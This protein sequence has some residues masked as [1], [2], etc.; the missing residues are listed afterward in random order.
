M[1]PTSQE[2][3]VRDQ[4]VF[5]ETS[6]PECSHFNEAYWWNFHWK[7]LLYLLLRRPQA[8]SLLTALPRLSLWCFLSLKA[9]RCSFFLAILKK[10]DGEILKGFLLTEEPGSSADLT[11]SASSWAATWST[12]AWFVTGSTPSLAEGLLFLR[13]CTVPFCLHL[14]KSLLRDWR[15]AGGGALRFPH[16]LAGHLIVSFRQEEMD[17]VFTSEHIQ[18]WSVPNLLPESSFQ[19]GKFFA[20]QTIPWPCCVSEIKEL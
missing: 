6:A 5:E 4:K 10:L 15:W 1:A 11:L 13:S 7:R 14:F 2:S 12:M 18:H 16:V 19:E 17:F 20:P 9:C 8:A 3:L